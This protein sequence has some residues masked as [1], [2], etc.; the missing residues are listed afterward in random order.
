MTLT[1]AATRRRA[2]RRQSAGADD[3]RDLRAHRRARRPRAVPRAAAEGEALAEAERLA[4][5]GPQGK[6]LFGVPFAVKDNIDVAGLPTTA[7]CPA[8]AYQPQRSAFV[9]E[10]LIAAGAIPIG[11]TNLDQFATGLVGVRSPYGVPRNALQRRSHPRRL[12]LGLGGGGR[13][14]ARAL[15]ARHRYGGLR[16]RAG[17]DQRHRR[18]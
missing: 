18:A 9:V 11:K 4:Q 3:P 7:A 12:Q 13:R 10:R 8:F 16:P 2:S 1:L 5:A 6:P 14:R 17:G 15:R